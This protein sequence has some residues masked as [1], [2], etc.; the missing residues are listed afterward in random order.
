MQY[1]CLSRAEI[2]GVRPHPTEQL[3]LVRIRAKV[4]NDLHT[5][6]YVSIR[7]HTSAESPSYVSIRQHT[8][9][10]V[11][12]ITF[13]RQDTSG[14]VR[15]RQHTSRQSTELPSSLG[16]I[17]GAQSTNCA[18]LT[19]EQRLKMGPI[20]PC[21]RSSTKGARWSAAA[22]GLVQGAAATGLV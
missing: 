17:S 18:S 21:S 16:R 10:Y 20:Y 2:N 8:S 4:R 1:A 6:A 19:L 22:R 3:A 9:A 14:Y 13:I 12:G 11:S 15:I 5:S 7:Q